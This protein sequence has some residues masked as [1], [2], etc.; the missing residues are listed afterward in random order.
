MTNKITLV[1][2]AVDITDTTVRVITNPCS[3]TQR[4][5]LPTHMFISFW[6]PLLLLADPRNFQG[7]TMQEVKSKKFT[8]KFFYPLE[9]RAIYPL[10]ENTTKCDDLFS[11]DFY[12]YVIDGDGTVLF[13]D[14]GE[15]F[16]FN[17]LMDGEL[18]DGWAC[19]YAFCDKFNIPA[20]K[21]VLIR[22]GYGALDEHQAYLKR[23]GRSPS[24][25]F[26]VYVSDFLMYLVKLLSRAAVGGHRFVI[27]DTIIAGQEVHLIRKEPVTPDHV[28]GPDYTSYMAQLDKLSNRHRAF[29]FNSL[30]RNFRTSRILLAQHLLSKQYVS[31]GMVSLPPFTN[32]IHPPNERFIQFFQD[33]FEGRMFQFKDGLRTFGEDINGNRLMVTIDSNTSIYSSTYFG[34]VTETFYFKDLSNELFLQPYQMGDGRNFVLIEDHTVPF[35][36][37]KILKNFRGGNFFVGLARP[38]ILSR[39]REYGLK[40]FGAFVDESYDD[41][42]DDFKRMEMVFAQ[43][44]K[45][46]SMTKEQIHDMYMDHLDLFVENSETVRE[47]TTDFDRVIPKLA[48][49]S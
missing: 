16:S 24:D 8:G 47:M 32:F 28:S 39:L 29:K 1:Y 41:E 40:T 33:N 49:L 17:A 46:L 15:S 12:K 3:Q 30:N 19:L 42:E 38:K 18:F 7:K 6:L 23:S 35:V 13:F 20:R 44:D 48:A 14:N 27:T 22:G 45:I 25:A 21:V 9:L 10:L 34:I 5:T 31:D 2:D 36:S 11:E 43:I 26:T 4:V 37:E